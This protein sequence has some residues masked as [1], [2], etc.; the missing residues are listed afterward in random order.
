MPLFNP[1]DAQWINAP[2]N[3]GWQAFGGGF[4][5]PQ[6]ARI[7]DMVYLRG[8][9]KWIS[10]SYD[11]M[12]LPTGFRPSASVVHP[13]VTNNGSF[14][15]I[16]AIAIVPSGVLTWGNIGGLWYVGLDGIFFGVD[17]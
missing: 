2:L 6:Y 3:P 13:V 8:V 7:G 9:T 14:V 4:Q 15:Q 17:P 10:G 12:T 1:P 11:I 16:G 5:L